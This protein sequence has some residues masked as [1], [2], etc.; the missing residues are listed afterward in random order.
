MATLLGA[1]CCTCLA[2]LL[3][4]VR[5][6]RR[7]IVG[8]TW[9]NDYN[10]MQHPTVAW[11]IWPFSNLSQQHPT[12]RN[13]SQQGGCCT[14]Q[15]SNTLR[16]NIVIVLLSDMIY[17]RPWKSRSQLTRMKLICLFFFVSAQSP[18]WGRRGYFMLCTACCSQ[19]CFG[20][21]TC[22]LCFKCVVLRQRW[23]RHQETN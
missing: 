20:V 15:C 10:I 7:N 13:T 17:F 6:F 3:R 5:M 9:P 8:R 18:P 19:L 16:W 1:T 4:L 2:T 23:F 11:K 12:C 21:P 14:Q 22:F